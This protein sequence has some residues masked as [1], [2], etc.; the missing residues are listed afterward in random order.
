MKK[1]IINKL[2]RFKLSTSGGAASPG[3]S[4]PQGGLAVAPRLCLSFHPQAAHTVST[5]APLPK[6]IPDS[7]L[8]SNHQLNF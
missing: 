8:I 7:F 6:G 5:G 3:I 1:G 2:E 4:A